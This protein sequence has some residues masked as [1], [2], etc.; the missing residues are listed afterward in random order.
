MGVVFGEIKFKANAEQLNQQEQAT[1]RQT[2]DNPTGKI[3]HISEVHSQQ[4]NVVIKAHPEVKDYTGEHRWIRD[5][6]TIIPK[7]AV[8]E[9]G[10]EL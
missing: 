4:D 10:T 3:M 8:I 9:S 1:H 2:Q 7:G 5:G 6:I